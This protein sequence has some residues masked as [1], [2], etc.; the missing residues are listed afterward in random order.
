VPKPETIPESYD[1]EEKIEEMIKTEEPEYV[2]NSV[3][4]KEKGKDNEKQETFFPEIE[5]LISKGKYDTSISLSHGTIRNMISEKVKIEN[6]KYLTHREFFDRV[7]DAIPIINHEMKDLTEI[8]E[9]AM[10][11]R[12]DASKEH[13][14]KALESVRNISYKL[15]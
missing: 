11:S 2:E 5:E 13:A 7:K 10:Y 4:E 12:I 3:Q 9:L 1:K 15:N 6:G 8:Y 14:I